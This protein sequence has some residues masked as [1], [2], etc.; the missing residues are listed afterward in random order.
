MFQEKNSSIFENVQKI[1]CSKL[2]KKEREKYFDSL[3]PFKITDHK[4]FIMP[5]YKIFIKPYHYVKVSVFGV[6]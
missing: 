2:Y 4:I 5:Y 3:N 1:Y 6:I